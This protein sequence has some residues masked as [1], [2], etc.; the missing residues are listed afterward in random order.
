MRKCR[1][2]TTLFG[3]SLMLLCF[4]A[5][6]GKIA[7]C[8]NY[9]NGTSDGGPDSE[10]TIE[11]KCSQGDIAARTL[12]R[13]ISA[14][15]AKAA[16]MAIPGCN[17]AEIDSS[18]A[19]SKPSW[20]SIRNSKSRPRRY[21]S[22][23]SPSKAKCQQSKPS[24]QHSKIQLELTKSMFYSNI[25]ASAGK[26]AEGSCNPHIDGSVNT[27]DASAINDFRAMVYADTVAS[28]LADSFYKVSSWV[29]HL[30]F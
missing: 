22:R 4:Q 7:T 10:E 20:G 28:L 1:S 25:I 30:A 19:L 21:K 23:R 13:E 26:N 11:F 2:C 17:C 24:Q 12:A 6:T 29:L 27:T 3:Y 14:D 8:Q 16:E 5:L 15:I 9:M 18:P